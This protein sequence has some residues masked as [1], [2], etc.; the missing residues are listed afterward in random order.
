MAVEKNS[1]SFQQA[2]TLGHTDSA[3]VP[4]ATHMWDCLCCLSVRRAW[5]LAA[6]AAGAQ[7]GVFTAFSHIGANSK[8]GSWGALEVRPGLG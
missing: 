8:Y 5:H 6:G 7:L 2:L 1:R 3:T 4:A